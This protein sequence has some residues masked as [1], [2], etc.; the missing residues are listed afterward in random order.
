MIKNPANDEKLTMSFLQAG[1]GY[2]F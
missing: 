1:I 2:K